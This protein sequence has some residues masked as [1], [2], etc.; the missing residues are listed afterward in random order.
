MTWTL[1]LLVGL[2]AG[3]AGGFFGIGGAIIIIPLL[4]LLMKFPQHLAQGTS[5]AALLLPIGFLAAWR[6]WQDGNVNVPAA[7]LIALGFFVGGWF[8]ANLAHTLD[9]VVLRRA[10]G[11]LLIAV[12]LRTLWGR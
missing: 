5:L 6:Y 2:V 3:V 4:V 8:G 1:Y 10:F 12:G 7:V 11:V 9:G